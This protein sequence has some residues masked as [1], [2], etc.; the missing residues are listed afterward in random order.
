MNH[1]Q[2]IPTTSRLWVLGAPDPEMEAI[3]RLLTEA[4]EPIMYAT[5]DGRRVHPGS[6]YRCDPVTATHYVECAP[7]GGRPADA[8]IIDHH[9][10][11]DPGY[12]RPP[13]EFLA[14]SSI[15][16]VVAELARLGALERIS[17]AWHEDTCGDGE[18]TPSWT[19][20]GWVVRVGDDVPFSCGV[21]CCGVEHHGSRY[22]PH[23]IIVTAAADHCLGAAYRGECPGVDPD[24]LMQWRAASR[25]QFQQRPVGDVLRDIEA[26][27][28]ALRAAPLLTL[29][30]R[31]QCW[32]VEGADYAVCDVCG[33][34]GYPY[35][36][37]T[38]CADMRRDDPIPELPEAAMR[39]GVS[40][41]SGPLI[42]PDGRKKY[43]CSGEAE[44]IRAFLDHWAPAQGLTDIYGDPERGFAGAYK[45]DG[46]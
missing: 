26:A 4:G 16:Q 41:I 24:E 27:Q 18:D 39:L 43:T 2:S 36:S 25:A 30:A 32:P 33:T 42:G 34:D 12:G 3:E 9:Q 6:A 37:C 8:V 11:G 44:H 10:P 20:D 23:D 46:E 1:H 5:A 21:E 17:A 45:P 29:H 13:A 38:L 35:S 19:G 22:I 7:V 14:A 40:Y 15:G 28:H 31:G